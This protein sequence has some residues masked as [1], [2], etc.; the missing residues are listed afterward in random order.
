[1]ESVRIGA[2]D[3]LRE[4][5]DLHTRPSTIISRDTRALQTSSG[6]VGHVVRALKEWAMP[7][8]VHP[9]RWSRG[10]RGRRP[11]PSSLMPKLDFVTGISR[12]FR[13]PLSA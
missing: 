1:M 3:C 4:G 11:P 12:E 2:L 7:L 9:W 6:R 5:E 8:L 10:A 13:Q